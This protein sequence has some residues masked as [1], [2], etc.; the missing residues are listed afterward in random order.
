M[1][2]VKSVLVAIEKEYKAIFPKSQTY[3]ASGCM[4]SG[5]D[6][7]HVLTLM[8]GNKESFPHGIEHNDPY[9]MQFWIFKPADADGKYVITCDGASFMVNCSKD[10]SWTGNQYIK[11]GWRKKNQIPSK[12]IPAMKKY[13]QKLHKIT[14]EHVNEISAGDY[15]KFL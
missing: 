6:D 15:K 1:E 7:A 2:N 9:R 12:M 10:I 5:D 13:F 11:T 8:L 3:I 4:S 14:L